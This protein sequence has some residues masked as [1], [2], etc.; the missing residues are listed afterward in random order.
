MSKDNKRVHI[1]YVLEDGETYQ[2]G[3]EPVALA[4]DDDELD[5]IVGGEKIYNVVPDWATR[6][7]G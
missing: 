2:G 6:G 4:V 5:R 7:D 1:I 3:E